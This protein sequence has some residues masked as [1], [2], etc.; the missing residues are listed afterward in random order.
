MET[1]QTIP[2]QS[3]V[4]LRVEEVDVSGSARVRYLRRGGAKNIIGLELGEKVRKQLIE[5][6]RERTRKWACP[7]C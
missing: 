6:L 2:A 7:A 4:M 5:G 3:Y 1:N